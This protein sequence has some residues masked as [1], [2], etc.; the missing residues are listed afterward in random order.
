[1]EKMKKNEKILFLRTTPAVSVFVNYSN[2]VS[3]KT[4]GGG[5]AVYLVGEI[6]L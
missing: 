3:F 5:E 2:P 4:D 1:M 6:M